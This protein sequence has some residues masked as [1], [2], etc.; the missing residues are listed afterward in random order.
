MPK[1]RVF[2]LIG[3][4]LGLRTGWLDSESVA[5]YG[6]QVLFFALSIVA[7]CL[8]MLGCFFAWGLKG[9]WGT[10][11][12]LEIVG[13][14]ACLDVFMAAVLSSVVSLSRYASFI[15]GDHCDAINAW[16]RRYA[17]HALDEPVC[18]DLTSHLLLGTGF[19]VAACVL[20]FVNTRLILYWVKPY[21]DVLKK[22]VVVNNTTT[23]DAESSRLI[24]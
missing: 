10:F 5:A 14:W 15:V 3:A 9:R 17:E 23:F 24:N 12:A 11:D 21:T 18:I 7:P 4:G 20:L 6:L 2:N 22:D 19:L 13:T 1:V 16:M 8:Q